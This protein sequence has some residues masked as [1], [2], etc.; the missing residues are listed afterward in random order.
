MGFIRNTNATFL[1][2]RL[3]RTVAECSPE[4]DETYGLMNENYEDGRKN[5]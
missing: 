4:A 5:R 2:E 1:I 3:L